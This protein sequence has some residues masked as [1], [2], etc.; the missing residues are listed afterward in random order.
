[1]GSLPYEESPHQEQI[2]ALCAE[3]EGLRY[4]KSLDCTRFAA[5]VLDALTGLQKSD[6]L[7]SPRNCSDFIWVKR[8]AEWFLDTYPLKNGNLPLRA[9]DILL[10]KDRKNR[11]S[12]MMAVGNRRLWHANPPKVY[13]TGLFLPHETSLSAVYRL[14]ACSRLPLSPGICMSPQ[15]PS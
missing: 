14:S 6:D 1:V 8:A 13:F 15:P 7:R 11:L 10:L 12:H 9:G 4:S 3:L 2:D 5:R